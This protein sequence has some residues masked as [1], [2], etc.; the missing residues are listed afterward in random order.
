MTGPWT[1]VYVLKRVVGPT[2]LLKTSAA[3]LVHG[4]AKNPGIMLCTRLD[5]ALRGQLHLIQLLPL[6]ANSKILERAL[7]LNEQRIDHVLE[8]QW[9]IP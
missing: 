2:L 1:P 6:P 5:V 9:K 8:V 7:S 3:I 4:S